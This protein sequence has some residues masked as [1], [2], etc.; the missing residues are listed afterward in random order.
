MPQKRISSCRSRS[1]ESRREIVA[2]ASGDVA[3]A[4]E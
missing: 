1:V 2:E 4:A 3:L